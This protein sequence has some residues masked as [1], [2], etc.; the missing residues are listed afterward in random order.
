MRALTRAAEGSDGRGQRRAHTRR[1]VVARARAQRHER[2]YGNVF[3][4]A[5]SGVSNIVFSNGLF[6][7][8]SSAGVKANLSASLP[9]VIISEGAHHID[10]FFSNPED[11]ADVTAA[12]AFE[13]AMI[14]GWIS[15][16]YANAAKPEL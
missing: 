4:W 2:A 8:W 10:T 12:R 3:D 5:R 16:F 11:P 15:D 9:A 7:P 1:G 14:R 13:M 6:D